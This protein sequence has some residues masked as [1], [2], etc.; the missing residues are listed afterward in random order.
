MKKIFRKIYSRISDFLKPIFLNKRKTVV[1]FGALV[2]FVIAGYY[3]WQF[4]KPK[5]YKIYEALIAVRDQY[6]T[7]PKEDEKTSLKAG[8]VLVVLPEGHNWSQTER[9]S[10][11]ILKLNLTEEQAAKLT[12]SEEK[13]ETIDLP[14]EEI[15]RA[16]KD[17]RKIDEE[18]EQRTTL[19]ARRYRIKIEELDPNFDPNILL[20]RQPFPDKTYDWGIV[21]KKPSVK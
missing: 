17:G 15:E 20:E 8:D 16:K 11:L 13:I 18:R 6:N 5:E 19:R 14:K 3:G 21:E 4:L 1:A 9:V 10:Y 7:D 12:S 2:F